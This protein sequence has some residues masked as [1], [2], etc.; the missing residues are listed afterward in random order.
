M[1]GP[2]SGHS[3]PVAR[4]TELPPL[5]QAP[6]HIPCFCGDDLS[7]PS[8]SPSGMSRPWP[9]YARTRTHS[10]S[11]TAWLGPR[12][13]EAGPAPICPQGGPLL[14]RSPG[15]FLRQAPVTEDMGGGILNAAGERPA[16]V[17]VCVCV[18]LSVCACVYERVSLGGG[19]FFWNEAFR[20]L[21]LCGCGD[22]HG[23]LSAS[24]NL[25]SCP[26][27]LRPV[28]LLHHTHLYPFAK[29]VLSSISLLMR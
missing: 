6:T 2:P 10:R 14:S 4:S 1:A 24:A 23:W 13:H 19:F 28:W 3:K 20:F 15:P 26:C 5:S 17:C 18:C 11:R 7:C 22:S 12:A 16:R 29:L 8:P 25:A 9:S 27:A 21:F